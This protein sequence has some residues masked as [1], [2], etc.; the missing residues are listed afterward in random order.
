MADADVLF[1]ACTRPA[2]KWGVP[3][4]GFRLNF[5]MTAVFAFLV[6]GSPAGFLLGIGVHLGLR[7]LTRIDPHFFGKWSLW[8]NTKAISTISMEPLIW[9]GS[10]LWPSPPRIRRAE[11]MPSCI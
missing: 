11:L 10:M 3:W 8:F 4:T 7:E 2:L 5:L 1:V 9:G 6:W